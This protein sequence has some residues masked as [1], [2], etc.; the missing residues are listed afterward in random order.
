MG[1]NDETLAVDGP[2]GE[3]ELIFEAEYVLRSDGAGVRTKF[4]QF[5]GEH[6][7]EA[8]AA[9]VQ[10]AADALTEHAQNLRHHPDPRGRRPE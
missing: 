5:S 7:R 4:F 3:G 2:D 8:E 10:Q 6:D 9:L 1:T